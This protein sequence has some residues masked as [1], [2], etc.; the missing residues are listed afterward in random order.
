M[1]DGLH[2]FTAQCTTCGNQPQQTSSK[3]VLRDQLKTGTEITNYCVSCDR[4]WPADHGT[5][6]LLARQLGVKDW[7]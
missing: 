7:R 4:S 6:A 3:M 5:R 2:K 1:I